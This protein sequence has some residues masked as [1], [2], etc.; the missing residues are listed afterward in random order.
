MDLLSLTSSDTAII[1]AQ[2]PTGLGHLRVTKALY[3]AMPP[4]C[5]GVL[6]TSQAETETWIHR[7]TSVTPWGKWLFEYMQYGWRE[8]LI[9]PLIRANLAN[10]GDIV[11]SQLETIFE[12]YPHKPT[13]AL[14]IAT[15]FQLAHQI[16]SIKREVS[17]NSGIKIILVVVVTDDSPQLAW[18]VPGA[19][20]TVVPSQETKNVLHRY[21]WEHNKFHSLPFIVS[22]YPVSPILSQQTSEHMHTLR[23]KQLDSD[24]TN[25]HIE[26]MVPI[27]G[28]G[29]QQRFLLDLMATLNK[30]Y[31]RFRFT[32][33]MRRVNFTDQFAML[34]ETL[35]YIHMITSAS[36]RETIDLYTG[37]YKRTPFAFEIT[38]PSEQ[39]F[40]C[41]LTPKMNGGVIMLLSYPIGRQE[42]DNLDFLRRHRLIPTK[43]EQEI[44]YR[45]MDGCE[46]DT[47]GKCKAETNSL[48][49]SRM[50]DK[51]RR[52]RGM[53][54][55]RDPET[56]SQFIHWCLTNRIFEAMGRYRRDV[57]NLEVAADGASRFWKMIEEI[58]KS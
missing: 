41:I 17:N 35:P 47:L 26:V 19:D 15:H 25:V 56:A 45:L 13:T 2:A 14:I 18:V 40:K 44:L 5:H 54:L 37:A 29:T 1:F 20:L 43:E 6:L 24:N 30:E 28:A 36:Q 16:A 23:L 39:A 21:A 31:M 34:L 48:L 32:T 33:V 12:Q 42:Y 51:A 10:N 11:K 57:H 4:A 22:S 55:P 52:W 7:I 46:A 58:V 27:S 53:T 3:E 38:K 50:R 49:L 9:A 8:R